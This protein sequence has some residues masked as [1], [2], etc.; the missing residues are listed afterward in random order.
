MRIDPSDFPRLSIDPQAR[1]Q[2]ASPAESFLETLKQAI[3]STN[4]QI[5]ESERMGI[6]LA[7]GKS[8]NIHETMIA[9]QKASVSAQLLVAVTNKLIEGYNNL[10][11]LR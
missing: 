5:K 9:M 3:S 2:G 11:Q 7:Q 10:T 4:H 1:A 6:E 8:G